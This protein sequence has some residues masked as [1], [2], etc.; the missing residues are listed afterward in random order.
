MGVGDERV[1]AGVAE[2]WDP[3]ILPGGTVGT[4]DSPKTPHQGLLLASGCMVGTVFQYAPLPGSHA[5]Q[6]TLGSTIAGSSSRNQHGL[7]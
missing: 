3:T 1:S 4:Q 6:G 5:V 7:Q 2:L